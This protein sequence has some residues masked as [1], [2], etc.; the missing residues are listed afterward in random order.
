[1][2]KRTVNV[3]LYYKVKEDHEKEFESIFFEM[4]KKLKE[5]R[6]GFIDAKLYKRVDEPREYLIYSEWESLDSFRKFVSSNEFRDT[7]GY[8]ASILEGRPF[9]R[10]FQELT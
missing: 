9:H 1:M 8:G 5:M 7:T 2:I 10:I 4:V 6:I 3:G